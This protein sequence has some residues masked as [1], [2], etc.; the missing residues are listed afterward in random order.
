MTCVFVRIHIKAWNKG[1]IIQIDRRKCAAYCT[2]F[3]RLHEHQF[4]ASGREGRKHQE[5]FERVACSFPR[6]VRRHAQQWGSKKSACHATHR[7]SLTKGREP[8]KVVATNYAWVGQK[9]SIIARIMFFPHILRLVLI[10]R[11]LYLPIRK[12]FVFNKH[13]I[14]QN[15]KKLDSSTTARIKQWMKQF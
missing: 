6:L 10:G 8:D 15:T 13:K 9:K 2:V 7:L 5:N 11:V 1:I 12:R 4:D 3:G 14:L